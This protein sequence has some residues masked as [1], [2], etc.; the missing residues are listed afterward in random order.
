M[1]A[2]RN[3][4]NYAEKELSARRKLFAKFGINL[5]KAVRNDAE[6]KKLAEALKRMEAGLSEH[7]KKALM[8][9]YGDRSLIR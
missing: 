5:D 9:D 8:Y 6:W 2:S 7:Y 1:D 4:P 3:D